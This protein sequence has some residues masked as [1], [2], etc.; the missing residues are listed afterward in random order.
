MFEHLT[1]DFET[2]RNKVIKVNKRMYEVQELM[3]YEHYSEETQKSILKEFLEV[4]DEL[5]NLYR[6]HVTY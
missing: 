4:Q 3:K 6:E 1:N 2:Y 5:N